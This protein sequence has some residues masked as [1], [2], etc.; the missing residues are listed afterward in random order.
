MAEGVI[1][2]GDDDSESDI[3]VISD[4][5]EYQLFFGIYIRPNLDPITKINKFGFWD[6]L[7]LM[8][9]FPKIFSKYLTMII[10]EYQKISIKVCQLDSV[11]Q[12]PSTS[13]DVKHHTK[14]IDLEK[15]W[16]R[17][18]R[19]KEKLNK[20]KNNVNEPVV[21]SS[22][23]SDGEFSDELPDLD[24]SSNTGLTVET[25]KGAKNVSSTRNTKTFAKTGP[26]F[27]T[28]SREKLAS[29]LKNA[30]INIFKK[31][32]FDDGKEENLSNSDFLKNDDGDSKHLK[33]ETSSPSSNRHFLD[34]FQSEN[35][36]TSSAE[37]ETNKKHS[38]KI[39]S[40]SGSENGVKRSVFVTLSPSSKQQ[41]KVKRKKTMQT[42]MDSYLPTQDIHV[43]DKNSDF[44]LIRQEKLKFPDNGDLESLVGNFSM[45][46][47]NTVM[48]CLEDDNED[49]LIQGL[50]IFNNFAQKYKPSEGIVTEILNRCLISAKSVELLFKG[51]NTLLFIHHTYPDLLNIAWDVVK[52]ILD[53]I[54]IGRGMAH[55]DPTI[56]T[57]MSLLLE[58]AIICYEDDFYCRDLIDQRSVR[59]SYA[60]RFLSH[61]LCFERNVKHVINIVICLLTS[62]EFS[63]IDV[64]YLS[65]LRPEEQKQQQIEQSLNQIQMFEISKIL[66]KMQKILEISVNISSSCCDAAKAIATELLKSYIYLPNT[67]K[68][69][70]IMFKLIQLVLENCEGTLPGLDFPSN[71]NSLVECYFKALPPKNIL[72][73]PTTP[74]SEDEEQGVAA[75]SDSYSPA[76]VEELSVLLYY[77]IYSYLK[78]VQKKSHIALRR[79]ARYSKAELAA[80]SPEIQENLTTLPQHVENLRR[81]FLMLTDITAKT[82]EYLKKMLCFSNLKTELLVAENREQ[83]FQLHPKITHFGLHESTVTHFGLHTS[84]VTHFGLHTSTITHFRL[85]T[86]TI[87]HFGVH[88]STITHFGLHTS[89]VTHFGLHTSTVTHFGLH[90]STITHFGLHTSTTSY[91]NNYTF[92]TS[93]IN[94]YTFWTSYINSYTFWTSASTVTHFG[95]H[96]STITHFGLHTSTVTHFGLHTSTITHFGLHTSTVTHFGLHT[97]TVTHFGLHTSTVT[98]F[99]LHTST[100]THFGL[101]TSTI[102]HFGLHTST[103]THFGLHT[104]TITHFGLHTSTVT[105]FGLHTST[106]THFGLHTSTVTEIKYLAPLKKKKNFMPYSIKIFVKICYYNTHNSTCYDFKGVDIHK[107]ELMKAILVF[108]DRNGFAFIFSL[109]KKIFTFVKN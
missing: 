29:I 93:Y 23:E 66:P 31:S 36:E 83:K 21:I 64:D 32:L 106:V 59:K 39:S 26:I 12:Q 40:L 85:H 14:K 30:K 104:S 100:V 95:L 98:H 42:T 70:L 68:S 19:E 1:E 3:I 2:I 17:L 43:T 74:Q 108:F 50:E 20:N 103:V 82:Q 46:C 8:V 81:H 49:A 38:E 89:T 6:I 37:S 16:C 71:L 61:D 11:I 51:F 47:I 79:R 69:E 87:T 44:K 63:E 77:L 96:T 5:E 97:S 94:S 54:G 73:P 27:D 45:L 67:L 55:Q 9:A 72:T 60:F 52:E 62:G 58:L 33:D 105:H 86:S 41:K 7:K 18:K 107:L 4:D 109:F 92:W 90:T 102:T 91:I 56:I 53:Q 10:S 99:G 25:T 22:D 15:T 76:A 35:L 101:H 57:K 78:C 75:V 24:E 48:M 34:L 28:K 65:S 13:R 80:V 88:T 84:T